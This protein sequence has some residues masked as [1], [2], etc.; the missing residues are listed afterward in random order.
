MPIPG[1]VCQ[2]PTSVFGSSNGSGFSST[3]RTT[4]K[5]A[6]LAPMPSASVKTAIERE[7]GRAQQASDNSSGSGSHLDLRRPPLVPRSARGHSTVTVP[8]DIQP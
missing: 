3:P 7:H 5:I 1:A 8:G 6:V 4:L 2:T